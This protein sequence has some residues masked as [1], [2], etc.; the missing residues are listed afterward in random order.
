MSFKS[1]FTAAAVVAFCAPSFAAI[2]PLSQQA[3]IDG[4][5]H[6][7]SGYVTKIKKTITHNNYGSNA[8]YAV[9]MLLTGVDKNSN[10][11]L[12][13]GQSFTFH[14]WKA[15]DRPSGW[16]GDG[17]QYGYIKHYQSIK[18]YLSFDEVTGAYHLLS[19]NGFD[20]EN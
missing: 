4:S 16:C 9:T 17:G 14:Y 2:P 3:R 18:A 5:S 19:P 20:L 8:N 13:N 7:V 1:I 6:I 11:E 15:E 10:G 12:Q